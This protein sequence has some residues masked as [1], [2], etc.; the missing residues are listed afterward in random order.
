[1]LKI[2]SAAA[3]FAFS[4]SAAHAD[5][6]SMHTAQS[7]KAEP[8]VVASAAEPASAAAEDGKPVLPGADEKAD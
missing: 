5:C 2:L 3:A 6:S 7:K 4:L 1:M 8:T